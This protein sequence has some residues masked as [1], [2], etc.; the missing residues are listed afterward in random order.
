MHFSSCNHKNRTNGVL[1]GL[2]IEQSVTYPYLELSKVGRTPHVALHVPLE[3][4]TLF[5]TVVTQVA[6]KRLL[7]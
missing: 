3:M 1:G 6:H 4:S 2:V 7:T 5:K